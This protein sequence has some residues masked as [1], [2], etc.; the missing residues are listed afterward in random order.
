MLLVP[1][2]AMPPGFVPIQ[3]QIPVVASATVPPTT[4]TYPAQPQSHNLGGTSQI[5]PPNNPTQ[6]A[7]AVHNNAGS[8][9]VFIASGSCTEQN[10]KQ[11]QQQQQQQQHRHNLQYTTLSRSNVYY[12][13]SLAII[14]LNCKWKKR[15]FIVLGSC[16]CL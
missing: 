4:T 1:F 11:Q 12:A 13:L 15:N 2:A 10:T 7:I 8:P 14:Q 9:A 3:G 6:N 5:L 16:H